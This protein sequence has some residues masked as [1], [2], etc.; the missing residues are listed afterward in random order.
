MQYQYSFKTEV[1]KGD[2]CFFTIN[3]VDWYKGTCSGLE[4]QF[5]K[6]TVNLIYW[7]QNEKFVPVPCEHEEIANREEFLE[8]QSRLIQC[9][10]NMYKFKGNLVKMFGEE[11]YSNWIPFYKENLSASNAYLLGMGLIE[12]EVEN[13]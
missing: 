3:K 7:A 12:R 4:A 1:S 5:D 8:W 11:S 2:D 13:G 6:E 10:K 9:A